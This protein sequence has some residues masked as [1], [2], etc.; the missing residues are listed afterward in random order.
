DGQGPE[1]PLENEL[2]RLLLSVAQVGARVNFSA[3]RARAQLAL[4]LAVNGPGRDA[5]ELRRQPLVALGVA[6]GLVDGLALDLLER[7]ADRERKDARPGVERGLLA[8][9]ARQVVLAD[10]GLAREHDGPLDRVLELA[11]VARPGV[12]REELERAA[13][14]ADDGLA[15]LL[16]IDLDEV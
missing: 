13:R 9:L 12:D 8:H 10:R 3:V 1:V 5:E 15:V 16:A 11:H 14:A 7:G 2:H 6:Q 4:E